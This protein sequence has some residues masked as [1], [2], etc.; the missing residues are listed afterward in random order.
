M[1][2]MAAMLGVVGATLGVAVLSGVIPVLNLEIYLI[3][4]V[5]VTGGI[6]LAIVLGL[7]AALGQMIAKAGLYHVARGATNLTRKKHSAGIDK[8]RTMIARWRNKPLTLLFVSGSV[9]LP[10]FYVVSL[11]AGMLDVRFRSFLAV[12]FAGRAARF[13]TIALL[14]TLA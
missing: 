11:A 8:A 13:V 9:G 12:G 3:G 4:V 10:P 14:A 6:P 7:I 5:A 2:S 1:D